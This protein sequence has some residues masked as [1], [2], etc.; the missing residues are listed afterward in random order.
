MYLFETLLAASALLAGSLAYLASRRLRLYRS[1]SQHQNEIRTSFDAGSPLGL[2]TTLRP[3]P[4]FDNALAVVPDVLP[5]DRLSALREE[6]EKLR[7]TERSYVP[8][9]KKGGTVAYETLCHSAPQVVAFYLSPQLHEL[10][11][12]VV[13]AKVVPTPLH[14]QSSCSILF[15]ERPGDHIGWHYDH[16]FYK[17]RHFTVL[18]PIVNR[19]ETGDGLSAARLMARIGGEERTIPTP[20]NQMV[21]FEGAR[22]QHKATPIAEGE[23]RIVLSM[24]FA[25][26]PRNSL[27]Q[28]AARRLKDTAFFGIRA[29]WT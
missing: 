19:D 22:V 5:P 26:D 1:L 3:I 15:Y 27:I 29:L 16:N 2:G 23:L 6:I 7:T 25:T 8:T 14:D 21:I 11:S 9:H 20:P 28:G 10:I 4:S 17:G 13:G 18:L 24:T 12:S